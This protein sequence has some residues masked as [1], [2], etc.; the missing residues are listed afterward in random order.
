MHVVF[1][2]GTLSHCRVIETVDLNQ[3]LMH[4]V[5]ITETVNLIILGLCLVRHKIFSDPQ[6]Y[7]GCICFG[8]KGNR[9]NILHT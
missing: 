3:F 2:I 8:G 5:F 9:E 4:I 7:L 6:I 1:I